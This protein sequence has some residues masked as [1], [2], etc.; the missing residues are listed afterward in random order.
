MVVGSAAVRNPRCVTEPDQAGV[1]PVGAGR[2]KKAAAKA[3]DTW[4]RARPWRT[5][6]K[7][8]DQFERG[9]SRLRL[10]NA[11][12]QAICEAIESGDPV[13]AEGMMREHSQTMIECIQTREDRDKS[14]TVADL[15]PFSAADPLTAAD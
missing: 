1:A 6:D 4:F 7:T 2:C 3:A 15:V 11:Q 10:G 14:L 9:I 12:H 5:L 8:P 13:R